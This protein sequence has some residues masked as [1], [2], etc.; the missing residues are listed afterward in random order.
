MLVER[1]GRFIGEKNFGVIHQRAANCGALAFAAREFLN[2]L[3]EPVRE[4]GTFGEMLQALVGKRAI[5]SGRHRGNETVFREGEVGNEIV[6]LKHESDFVAQQLKKVTMAIDFDAID[7]DAPAVRSIESSKEMQQCTFAAAGWPAESNRLTLA[8][9]KVHT[10]QYGDSAIVISLPDV[11][12]AEHQLAAA[13]RICGQAAHSN[14]SAST[15]RMRI[16]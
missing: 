14:R 3:I 15:A 5:G 11:F 4:T 16:A 12:G 6:K 9:F 7:G 10:S 2:L 13:S 1:T 8:G